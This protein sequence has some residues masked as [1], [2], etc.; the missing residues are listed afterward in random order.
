M[1]SNCL[2]DIEKELG[3]ELVPDNFTDEIKKWY[4]RYTKITAPNGK[5]IHLLA[6][7]E[8]STEKI[9]RCRCILEHYL[10]DFK[11]SEYG[12]DKSEIANSMANNEAALLI[13][14]GKHREDSNEA[15]LDA[16]MTQFEN[17]QDLYDEEITV[18]G[19]LEYITN[20]YENH[21]DASLEEILHL[22]HEFGIG[23]DCKRESLGVLHEFQ[24]EIKVQ[25]EYAMPKNSGIWAVD[26][27]EWLEELEEEGSLTD[28]YL[29]AVVD[30]YYGYWGA[31]TESNQGMHGFYIPKIREDLEVKDPNGL[32][33]VKKFFHPYIKYNARIASE[34][35]GVFIMKFD[36]NHPYTYKSQYLV[37]IT[38]T[39]AN[40]V[41]VVINGYDNFITGNSG[42]NTVIFSGD[43]TD[44]TITK[45]CES[46][47]IKDNKEDRDGITRV[48]NINRAQFTAKTID[49]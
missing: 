41:D 32:K 14:N 1:K 25:T 23:V 47:V 38:L 39:G 20:D 45:I 16:A 22:V 2:T 42:I 44:Y 27:H 5:P 31:F 13:I 8:L 46:I 9:Y 18:E 35:E 43:F 17:C 37:D 4:S 40:N 12:D 15:P 48:K 34:F 10:T 19:D 7:D 24:K 11:G 49:L 33:L 21:R 6:Q 30:V 3:I 28:E 29:A 36:K 26:K